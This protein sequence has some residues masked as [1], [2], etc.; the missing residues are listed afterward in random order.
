MSAAPVCLLKERQFPM[1]GG[2][3]VLVTEEQFVA[4]CCGSTI[5]WTLTEQGMVYR[6]KPGAQSYADSAIPTGAPWSKNNSGLSLRFSC[7][8]SLN[9][10]GVN[11]NIQKGTATGKLVTKKAR[12]AVV[13]WSGYA[14][15]QA[16]NY[17]QF[18][19]AINGISVVTGSSPGGGNGCTAAL[20]VFSKTSPA[21]VQLKVGQ[22]TVAMSFDSVDKNFNTGVFFEIS[23]NLLP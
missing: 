20:A 16:I 21:T 15:G 6:N 8:S 3:P 10:G 12:Q 23:I 9:C 4:C 2:R 14:E 13:S 7:E 1:Q 18:S 19:L 11:D 17:D 22:N 5:E